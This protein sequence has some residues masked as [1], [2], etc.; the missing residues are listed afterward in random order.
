M[1]ELK[2]RTALVTGAS[3]GLGQAIA[4]ALT[5]AGAQVAV[6]NMAELSLAETVELCGAVGARPLDVTID[7]RDLGQIKEGVARVEAEFGHVD[8][9]V[10]NAG[11]NRP[12]PGLDVDQ[13]NWD[14]QFATNVRG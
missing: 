14:D 1:F 3:T 13:E 11:I 7:V 10:N 4:K 5:V 2:G 6:S 9:L 12:A 8:I